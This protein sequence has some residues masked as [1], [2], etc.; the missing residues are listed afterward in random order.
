MLWRKVITYWRSFLITCL[1]AYGCLLRK[2]LYTLPPIENSDKWTH[3]LAFMVLT[4]TL[5]WDSRKVG[6][7]SWKKWIL[8][9]LFPAL[10]GGLIELLQQRYFYPRTG[11]WADWMADC[12]GVLMGIVVWLIATLWYEHRMAK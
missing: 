6:L 12:I 2:P 10:Y 9:L 1:I 11:E 5:L 3:W 4:L 7:I 8:V